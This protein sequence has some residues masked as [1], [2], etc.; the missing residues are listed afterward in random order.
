MATYYSDKG[1]PTAQMVDQAL[2]PKDAKYLVG[3]PVTLK[4]PLD[5]LAA[6]NDIV[7][8]ENPFG[9]EAVI[10]E[11][12]VHIK[13]AGGTATAVIDV[14]ITTAS[15]GTGDDIFDGVDANAV[16]L[17]SMLE[18]GAGTNAE[19]TGQVW[20]IAGGTNDFVTAKLL[21][22]AAASLEADLYLVCIPMDA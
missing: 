5:A 20:N 7:F 9:K 22:A 21:V 6:A 1:D 11:S 3:F 18:A 15:T 12:T 19:H 17:V 14:D 10:I 8:V 2:A 16:S 13:V 4:I